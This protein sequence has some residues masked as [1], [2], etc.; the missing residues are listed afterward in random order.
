VRIGC[1]NAWY[2]LALFGAYYWGKC[3]IMNYLVAVLASPGAG[4][5]E[6]LFTNLSHHFILTLQAPA[7]F[8]IAQTRILY[9][10]L[11]DSLI[12]KLP[13]WSCQYSLAK[14]RPGKSSIDTVSLAPKRET[15]VI[16]QQP[17][18]RL[19]TAFSGICQRMIQDCCG[20]FFDRVHKGYGLDGHIL[21]GDTDKPTRVYFFLCRVICV[22]PL[23]GNCLSVDG[24]YM[25]KI[26]S[27][28]GYFW[29]SPG[30]GGE[31]KG[32]RAPCALPY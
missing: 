8:P 15:G 17:L 2:P 7:N 9:E 12:P 3:L 20:K 5:L 29:P 14:F 6:Y 27:Q 21:S 13:G 19:W 11:G 30:Q 23:L 26:C 1:G 10:C 16:L 24:E 4:D 28:V 32:F 22:P 31:Q 18:T 25:V